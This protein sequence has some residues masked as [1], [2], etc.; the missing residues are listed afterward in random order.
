MV[1][2]LVIQT[3]FLGDVILATSIL[4]KLHHHY[5]EAAIDF[6]VRKGNEQVVDMHPFL[7]EVLVWNK[8]ENK[9][10]NLFRLILKIRKKKY[11]I[12]VNLHRFAASGFITAFSNAGRTTGFKKNPLSFLYTERHE[13][14][15]TSEGTLHETERN[16]RLIAS[17]TDEK[18]LKPVLYPSKEDS[19]A[20]FLHQQKEYI[21]IAPASI[22]FT[23]QF[24]KE[25]WIEL[26]S[27][28]SKPSQDIFLLGSPADHALCGEIISK[29]GNKAINLAG[30]LSI[31]QTAALMKNAVMNYVND[32]APL[33]IA[34]S[35]N[36]KVTAIFCST[37]PEFGFGPLSD[38][39]HTVETDIELHGYE[40]CPLGHFRCAFSIDV[41][42]LLNTD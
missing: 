34:S 26:I 20:V 10:R 28:I 8:R 16:Q 33:H 15:I 39:S 35:M 27:C 31:L 22:W 9:Y 12:V 24:P 25:K 18:A 32:S 19:A 3:A 42:K 29:S 2:I 4:E 5:P 21:C 13:H 14:V 38:H 37:V 30:K 40:K 23:K 36:A 41:K 7:N 1:R 11:E 17:L 6:L